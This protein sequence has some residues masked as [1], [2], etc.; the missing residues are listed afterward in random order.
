MI[1]LSV[2]AVRYQQMIGHEIREYRAWCRM[3]KELTSNS[4]K[5]ESFDDILEG[6]NPQDLEINTPYVFRY[7]H[8]F[9][10]HIFTIKNYYPA[11]FHQGIMIEYDLPSTAAELFTSGDALPGTISFQN[12]RYVP[13]LVQLKPE[14]ENEMVKMMNNQ[15]LFADYIEVLTQEN[16][17]AEQTGQ[18]S[19]DVVGIDGRVKSIFSYQIKSD[20]RDGLGASEVNEYLGNKSRNGL[21]SYRYKLGA[22]YLNYQN[23]EIA[24]ATANSFTSAEQLMELAKALNIHDNEAWETK[25]GDSGLTRAALQG[26]GVTTAATKNNLVQGV[27]VDK[28]QKKSNDVI[29]SMIDKDR[30]NVRIELNYITKPAGALTGFTHVVLDKRI[31]ILS[32][33]IVRNVRS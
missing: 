27:K 26:S 7:G 23:I 12:I 4:D 2:K 8:K 30:N 22:N 33:S 5:N 13:D 16:T 14:I 15:K 25:A 19:Y 28:A 3:Y 6:A 1:R 10:A 29:S 11:H 24:N 32:G 21:G 20:L 18:Q 17:I 9:M 31:Q